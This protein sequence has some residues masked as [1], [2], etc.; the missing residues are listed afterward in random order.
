[1]SAACPRCGQLV[2]SHLLHK[3]STHITNEYAFDKLGIGPSPCKWVARDP[4]GLWEQR[5]R[6]KRLREQ[7]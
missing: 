4:K 3:P 5:E 1:V 2:P 6:G 7:A